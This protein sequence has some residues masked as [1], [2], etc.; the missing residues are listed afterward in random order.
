MVTKIRWRDDIRLVKCFWYPTKF[1]NLKYDIVF[2]SWQHVH[3]LLRMYDRNTLNRY[4]KKSLS[5]VSLFHL[6]LY[7]KFEIAHYSYIQTLW[8][9]KILFFYKI[10]ANC[11]NDIYVFPLDM[12][13][14]YFSFADIFRRS[15]LIKNFLYRAMCVIF[16]PFCFFAPFLLLN[17]TH[18]KLLVLKHF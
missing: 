5:A 12:V 8:F 1:G 17:S 9:K 15:F 16:S 13:V 11:S 2:N 14:F 3:V 10:C 4:L 6:K 7:F 18:T